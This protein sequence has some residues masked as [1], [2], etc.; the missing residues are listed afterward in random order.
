VLL[1]SDHPLAP[2]I[3]KR[4]LNGLRGLSHVTIEVEACPQQATRH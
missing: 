3:Y 2:A 1:A 4:R